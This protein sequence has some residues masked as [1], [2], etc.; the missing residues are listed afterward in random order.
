MTPVDD[1]AALRWVERN[2]DKPHRCPECHA[3]ATWER[4]TYGPRTVLTCPRECGI[5]WR[6]G[7]RLNRNWRTATS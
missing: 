1:L 5:Q 7:H 6:A 2:E 4:E 3:V